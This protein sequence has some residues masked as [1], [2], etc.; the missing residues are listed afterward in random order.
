[1]N[2][3]NDA[4]RTKT[5]LFRFQRP[6]SS[7][8]QKKLAAGCWRPA[9]G[10]TLIEMTAAAGL[11]ALLTAAAFVSYAQSWRHSALRHN[12]QQLYLAARYA[13]ALAIESGRAAK[14]VIDRDNRSFFIAQDDAE[15]G[16]T[17]RLSNLWQRPVALAESVAFEQIVLINASSQT[18]QGAIVFRAD[19]GADGA[20]VQLSNGTRRYTVKIS[21]ATGRATLEDGLGQTTT[22]D[23]ID[24]DG[25]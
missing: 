24:L 2:T 5:R 7:S 12:A 25:T 4:L 17:R 10:F 16:E 8:Q 21:P 20:M 1:M 11:I 3:T 19:G 6:A 22:P 13:R 15:T 14:L 23:Q 9:A 18:A